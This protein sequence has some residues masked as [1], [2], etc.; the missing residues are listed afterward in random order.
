[1]YD[2]TPPGSPTRDRKNDENKENISPE[3]Q[4]GGRFFSFQPAQEPGKD[5]LDKTASEFFQGI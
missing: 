5:I 3:K 4:P 1:M 2:N